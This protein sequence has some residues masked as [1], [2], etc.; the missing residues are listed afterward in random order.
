M[1]TTDV[2][3]VYLLVDMKVHVLIKLTGKT[4]EVMYE[5]N[6]KYKIF[7]VLDDRKRVLYLKSKK[8]I[9]GCMQPEILWYDTFKGYL[10]NLGFKLNKYDLYVVNKVINGKQCTVCWYLDNNKI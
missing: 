2:A 1:A 4:V 10:E 7:V 9:Y 5:V 8:T 3:G 6:N